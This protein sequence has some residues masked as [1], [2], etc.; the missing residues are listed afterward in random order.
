MP[1]PPAAR[2]IVLGPAPKLHA[3]RDS[4]RWK[5]G[6]KGLATVRLR[7]DS[8]GGPAGLRA[9]REASRVCSSAAPP[10]PEIVRDRESQPLLPLAFQISFHRR[11]QEH[12]RRNKP[13][14]H[15][16]LAQLPRQRAEALIL[17]F[18]GKRRIHVLVRARPL[19]WRECRPRVRRQDAR[20]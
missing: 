19:T 15:V 17:F 8:T 1:V 13:E 10:V 2:D 4:S 3:S 11:S 12:L 7:V 6:R 20:R 9:R 18:T 14:L 5:S 16:Q